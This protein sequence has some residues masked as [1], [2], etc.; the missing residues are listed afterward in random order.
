MTLE[1]LEARAAALAE[2]RVRKARAVLAETL[3]DDAP[4]GIRVEETPDGVMLAGR[5][6][7]RRRLIDPALRWIVE[8]TRG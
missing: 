8:R 6:L 4:R 7:V 5:G 3:R 2:R 1:A